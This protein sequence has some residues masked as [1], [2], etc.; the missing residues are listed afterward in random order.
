MSGRLARSLSAL[1]LLALALTSPAAAGAHEEVDVRNLRVSGTE[2]EWQADPFRLDWEEAA[3]EPDSKVAAVEYQLYDEAGAPLG[4]VVEETNQLRAIE[5][6]RVPGPGVY[7]ISVWLRALDGSTGTPGRATLRY[8]DVPPA[9]PSPSAPGGWISG[10]Q[11]ALLRIGHPAAPLPLSGIRGYAISIDG[12]PPCAGADRCTLAETDLAGGIEDDVASLGPLPEGLTV[13]RVVAVSGAGVA[14]PVAT[15]SF[16]VDATPPLVKIAGL[17]A[18]WAK[19]P[20]PVAASADDGLSG[21]TAAGPGGPFTAI[22]V[23]GAPAQIAPGAT[24][25]A[26]VVG[27]GLHRVT[28]FARDAAGNA[29]DGAA[30]APEPETALVRIDEDAPSVQFSAA[31]DPNEPERIEAIVED[32]LSG[33]SQSQGWIGIRQVGG[34]GQF[35][36]LPTATSEGRLRAFWDSDSFPPGKYEFRAAGYDLAGNAAAGTTRIRGGR[37]VLVNPV[38]TETALAYGLG[39]RRSAKRLIAYGQGVRL[40]G[41]LRKPAGGPVG[42]QEITITELFGDGS[43][44][45]ARTT[46]SRTAK[47]GTFSAWLAPGPS[48]RVVAGFDGNRVLTRATGGMVQVAVRAGVSLRVSSPVAFVGERAVVFRGRLG[49]RGT[50]FP[51]AGRPVELQFRYPGAEWS[52]FRTVQTDARGGFRY[53]YAFSDDDSRGVRF[54]F[55]AY[56]AAEDGWPYEPTYSRPVAVTGR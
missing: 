16:H 10:R 34:H 5:R 1:A 4:P 8:D 20:V 56:V 44:A 9:P 23:D 33:P 2:G 38:K 49:H 17:P 29:A 6:L 7:G 45:R 46:Y 27:S 30:G 13:A 28:A 40:S 14:S 21:M 31:Q 25:A 24:A 3:A 15:A 55:R 11:A 54:Q 43:R 36:P 51:R 39:K 35:E 41:K 37:M 53:P 19:G 52:D 18:G 22:A 48:R 42:G 50:D 47:D 26:T 32:G 12:G